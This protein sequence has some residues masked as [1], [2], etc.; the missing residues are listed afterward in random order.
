VYCSGL[1]YDKALEDSKDGDIY[2]NA[3][4]TLIAAVGDD[5]NF[6]LHG[7]SKK[8]QGGASSNEIRHTRGW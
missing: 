3:H 7:V 1:F 8:F 4:V 6:G 5:A 2:S